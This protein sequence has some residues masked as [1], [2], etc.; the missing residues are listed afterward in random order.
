MIRRPPR[1]TLFPYTTLFR[2]RADPD[3]VM[4][5][6]NLLKV[7]VVDHW[8]QTETGWAIAGNPLGLGL[9]PVKIGSAGGALPG[10]R[11]GLLR[12]GGQE[13]P[14]WAKGPSGLQ[15]AVPAARPAAP[16]A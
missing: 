12:G 11:V 8:W 10:H 6:E 1:S 9:L 4:W 7:P 13:G 15:P 14:G 3:T 16:L 5:A 2:S